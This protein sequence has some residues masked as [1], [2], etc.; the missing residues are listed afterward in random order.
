ME[1][2]GENRKKKLKMSI[3]H[4]MLGNI[5]EIWFKLQLL[6][7][8]YISYVE[9]NITVRNFSSRQIRNEYAFG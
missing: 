6:K 1:N 9:L 8:L 3:R 4:I 7:P 5:H 2:N